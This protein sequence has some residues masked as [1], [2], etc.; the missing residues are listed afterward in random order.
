MGISDWFTIFGLLLA[1][2]ALYSSDERTIL[3]LKLSKYDLKFLLFEIFII[4]TLIK[5]D[6]IRSRISYLNFLNVSWG[7]TPSNWALIIFLGLLGY[8]GFKLSRISYKLPDDKLLE[9]YKKFLKQNFESFYYLFNKYEK[10]SLDKNYFS[11][12]KSIIFDPVFIESNVKDPYYFMEYLDVMDTKAFKFY[13]NHLV[14]NDNSIF[15]AELKKNNKSTFVNEENYFLF[16]LLAKNP[17]L[18]MKIGGLKIIKDWY[19]IHLENEL[20]KGRQSIYNQKTEQLINN[21]E[22]KFPIYLHI[23]FIQLLYNE[24]IVKK[25]DVDS[26]SESFKN[27]QSIYSNMIEKCIDGIQ[28]SN[29]DVD[30]YSEYPTYYHFMISR[31]FNVISDWIKI[32]NEDENYI[33]ESSYTSYFPS[34]LHS[35][36]DKLI[37][38]YRK[39]KI[40]LDFLKRIIHYNLL[41][42][43]YKYDL[44]DSLKLKIEEI[45][46]KNL[47]KYLVEEILDYSLDEKFALS[48]NDFRN[49]EF[50]HPGSNPH[51]M[52][53]IAHLHEVMSI[54]NLL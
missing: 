22:I 2:Y 3:S 54:N 13:F 45:C 36:I 12:Y 17:S 44:K 35:C 42:V 39:E 11:N 41:K 50:Y 26:L 24:G 28:K 10:R 19:L 40:S 46:L 51:E 1:V 34:C 14:N 20:I 49:K 32:F 15:Y 48:F 37:E 43:Y 21:L 23:L 29:L 52:K 8:F 4:L 18:F 9:F 38:G 16:K 33:E 7:I 27:M 47:P 30:P 31:I 25:V 5:Y 6:E 53:I